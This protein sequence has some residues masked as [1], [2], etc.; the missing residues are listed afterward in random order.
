MLK[1]LIINLKNFNLKTEA[2]EVQELIKYALTPGAEYALKLFQNPKYQAH[3]I[4]LLKV[5]GFNPTQENLIKVLQA[6]EYLK[7]GINENNLL[8]AGFTL[9]SLMPNLESV[10]E[11][12]NNPNPKVQATIDIAKLIIKHQ[13]MIQGNLNRMKEPKLIDYFQKY[14]P[15][16]QLLVQYGDRIWAAVREWALKSTKLS[17]EVESLG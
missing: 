9:I 6:A 17:A 13:G 16:G 8:L 11:L 7:E 10:V 2:L 15:N 3:L 5:L 14:I 12:I 4:N 1:E